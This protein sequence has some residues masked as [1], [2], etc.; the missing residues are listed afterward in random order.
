VR[1]NYAN[2]RFDLMNRKLEWYQ[3]HVSK[4]ETDISTFVNMLDYEIKKLDGIINEIDELTQ[5]VK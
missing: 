1:T 3:V 5:I 4:P 2:Q